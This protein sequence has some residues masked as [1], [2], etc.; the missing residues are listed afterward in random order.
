MAKPGWYLEK[1]GKYYG[2]FSRQKIQQYFDSGK[3]SEETKVSLKADGAGAVPFAQIDNLAPPKKAKKAAAPQPKPAP[4]K[5][6]PAVAGALPTHFFLQEADR[7][8]GPFELEQLG[9]LFKTGKIKGD[10]PV[11]YPAEDAA[12]ADV[13]SLLNSFNK[14][15][16]R[17]PQGP[18]HLLQGSERKGPYDLARVKAMQEAHQIHAQTLIDV[19]DGGQ[20]VMSAHQWLQQ[21]EQARGAVEKTE[22]RAA[23]RDVSPGEAER[24]VPKQVAGSPVSRP[25]P[26]R[27]PR[28]VRDLG[29]PKRSP[30]R[31]FG[32]FLILALVS[33]GVFGVFQGLQ[34]WRAKSGPEPIPEDPKSLRALMRKR[35]LPNF[36]ALVLPVVQN[37]LNIPLKQVKRRH[38][39][40]QPISEKAAPGLDY[41]V[42]VAEEIRRE[43]RFRV[44]G[45]FDYTYLT[46]PRGF[47]TAIVIEGPNF[48]KLWEQQFEETAFA[49]QA[50]RLEGPGRI[51]WRAQFGE[52][53][54]IEVHWQKAEQGYQMAFILVKN[55]AGP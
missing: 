40:E 45:P 22:A 36:N 43:S 2:P 41:Q 24:P 50:M 6:E 19:A 37:A 39:P 10:T 1:K 31:V 23:Q 42:F 9:L 17:V 15:V 13:S 35:A 14:P 54:V 33:A 16:D 30:A 26:A 11:E 27:E 4:G 7:S 29:P 32:M 12:A 51:I 47:V 25:V 55:Q 53:V 49:P 5:A 48:H 18:V 3:I 34:I 28:G 38:L 46:N 8:Q 44:D 52:A 20:V 21:M